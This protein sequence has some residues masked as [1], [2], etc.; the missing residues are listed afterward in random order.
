MAKILYL[1]HRI[2]YP[3]DKGDKITTYHIL[4]HLVSRHEVHL[5]SFVDDPH[6]WQYEP[7]LRELC[8]GVLLRPIHPRLRRLRSMSAFLTGASISS[9]YYADRAMQAWVDDT[10]RTQGIGHAVVYSSPV[11]QYVA[12]DRHSHVRRVAHFAD[13]DSEKWRQYSANH[14]GLMAWVY[15]READRLLAFDRAMAARMDMTAFVTEADASLFRRLAPEV[16]GRVGVIENGVD[17]GYFDPAREYTSPYEPGGPVIVFTGVMD[18]WA[19]VDAVQWFASEILPMVRGSIPEA[20]FA[21]VGSRPT[22]EVQGLGRLPGVLVTG[23]VPDVRPYVHHA[24][25]S[26]APMRIARGVQNKVLEAFAMAKPVLMTSG[27]AEG[28][29]DAE[30]LGAQIIDR[31]GDLARRVCH[32]LRSPVADPRAR[33][34]VIRHYSWDAH[35]GRLDDMLGA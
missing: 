2:P 20:R 9:V 34:Y 1:T 31:A 22:A 21:I 10:V 19:N 11:A 29:R 35:L 26:V 12:H 6:D 32:A 8:A 16:D 5:G 18:Y 14:R 25:V 23:R 13:V 15:R 24:A 33:E 27:A 17:T 30:W 28:L 3:A 7:R 4:R